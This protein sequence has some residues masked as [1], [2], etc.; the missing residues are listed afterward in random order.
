MLRC[1]RGLRFV[2]LTATG[3]CSDQVVDLLTSSVNAS[4]EMLCRRRALKIVIS[5]WLSLSAVSAALAAAAALRCS[6]CAALLAG[7]V[8]VSEFWIQCFDPS[9]CSDFAAWESVRD[10]CDGPGL[11]AIVGVSGT[12]RDACVDDPAACLQ[13]SRTIRSKCASKSL[14]LC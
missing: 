7:S 9:S 8:A 5:V 10:S 12:F 1:S 3:F 6:A 4:G 14:S 2:G 13:R 11:S